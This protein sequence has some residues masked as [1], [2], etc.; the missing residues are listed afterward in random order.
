[1][2]TKRWVPYLQIHTCV[3]EENP[4]YQVTLHLYCNILTWYLLLL[5]QHSMFQWAAF[6]ASRLQHGLCVSTKVWSVSV[7]ECFVGECVS[8]CT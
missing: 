2:K 4:V 8:I 6:E 5:Q 7:C 1:M 3:S